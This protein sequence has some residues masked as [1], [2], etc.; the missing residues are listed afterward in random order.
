[1][2]KAGISFL[3][4]VCVMM[5]V[6]AGTGTAAASVQAEHAR[7]AKPQVSQVSSGSAFT[8]AVKADGTL[9]T[10]G[11]DQRAAQFGINT[12][13][14]GQ[15]GSD[16]NWSTVS[17][18]G[19]VI[20]VIAALKTDGTLWA[21]G[22]PISWDMERYLRDSPI[23]PMVPAQVGKDQD[24]AAVSVGGAHIAALKR[25]GTLW[26]WGANGHGQLGDGT[27]T[28]RNAPAQVGTDRDWASVSAGTA[29]TAALKRN[30]TLWTWG[31][32]MYGQ[33]GIGTGGDTRAF[34]SGTPIPPTYADEHT[35]VQVGKDRDWA[36]VSA[37]SWRT[38]AI[39]TDGTLWA[40]GMHGIA[41][42]GVSGI[43]VRPL[44]LSRDTDWASVSLGKDH[45]AALKKDGTLWTWGDN[46][47]GKLGIGIDP[48]PGRPNTTGRGLPAQVGTDR[49][50]AV[51]SVGTHHTAALKAD[52]T[53]WTWGWNLHGQLGDGSIPFANGTL[54]IRYVP[55]RNAPAAVSP[56]PDGGAH[57]RPGVPKMVELYPRGRT[58]GVSAAYA[59]A[60]RG[61]SSVPFIEKGRTMVPLRFLGEQLGAVVRFDSAKKEVTVTKG[62][63]T[64]QLRLGEKTARVS[65]QGGVPRTV[66][67]DVPARA[68]RGRTVVPLRFVSE[69]LGAAV[70]RTDVGTIIVLQ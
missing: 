47:Y 66:A 42:P 49:A 69:A 40:W 27:T 31:W 37:G 39:K 26:T 54:P 58:N 1:M 68:V 61:E 64:I 29:H 8:A 63:V 57:A 67:L 65:Q 22:W 14:S 21:W 18:G 7:S 52:G 12:F 55:F 70:I 43:Q 19:G 15:V 34:A 10:W 51:V 4:G 41:A 35:P 28:L 16:T 38:V 3:A 59:A 23:A 30:G 32:N 60:L 17:A 62:T 11:Y 33:L 9:W 53:L 36:T 5:W 56:A 24:W 2:R 6:C 20:A 13:R 50:W 46:S 25:D 48:V 44:R 45:A